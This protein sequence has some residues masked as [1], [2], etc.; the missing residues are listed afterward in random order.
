M[1]NSNNFYNVNTSGNPN[2]NNNANNRNGV[3]L[4]FCKDIPGLTK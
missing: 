4:G 3:S 2:N 1:N